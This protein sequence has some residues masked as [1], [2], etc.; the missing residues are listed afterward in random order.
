MPFT[1]EPTPDACG[2]VAR[3]NLK[4]PTYFSHS[5]RPEDRAIN[6]HFWKLF[7]SAGFAFTVD[8]R[9]DRLS[10]PHVELIL[11]RCPCFVAVVTHRPE[12]DRYR[13]SPYF[14]F[15]YGLAV[16]ANK[17]RLVF[18]ERAVAR[19]HY[20]ESSR[21]VFDR[22]AIA[23]HD[24][25]YL[26]AIRQ[27]HRAG[28]AQVPRDDA[29]R[30]SVG[31]LLPRAAAYREATPAIVDVLRQAGY[32]VVTVHHDVPNPHELVL[33]VDRHDFLV[34]DVGDGALPRWLVPLLYGRFVPMVRLL[35]HEPAGRRRPPSKLVLGHAV[36]LVAHSDELVIRWT[37][38]DELVPRL[39]S[40]VAG[41]GLPPRAELRTFEQGVGYLTSLG[42]SADASA[43]V[44]NAGAQNGFAGHLC[45]R[46]A[47]DHVRFFHYIFGNSIELGT[48]WPDGLE[49]RLRASKLF[50][51]L[52]T[53]SYWESPVCQHEFSIAEELSRRGLLRILPYF[54]D[55]ARQDHGTRLQGRSLCGLALDRQ[56]EQI[57]RDVDRYLTSLE[58]RD[59]STRAW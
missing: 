45:R 38:V 26:G 35:H 39:Q 19:H 17:P 51:A 49:E 56:L 30:G 54:L 24:R 41:L 23:G 27:L 18:L 40:E 6:L 22:G 14:V 58:A 50:V 25:R 8:P 1:S 47:T 33:E 53:R 46:L 7:W 9:P 52:I 34:A 57:A 11:R 43:F 13:T 32:E 5:C 37:R 48:P 36:E 10:I 28:A 20:E 31:L 12:V 44:S 16:Q 3:A 55:E 2:A 15:E 59:T 21:F 29:R 42:R 4:I